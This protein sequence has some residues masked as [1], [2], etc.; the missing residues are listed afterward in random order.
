MADDITVGLTELAA[1]QRAEAAEGLDKMS[2]M[3]TVTAI[4]FAAVGELDAAEHVARA[5]DALASA[6]T[7]L[8][9]E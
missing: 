1:G 4:G 6:V 8:E 3:L 5:A 2:A 7:A 9:R